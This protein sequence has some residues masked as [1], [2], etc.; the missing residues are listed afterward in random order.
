[1][2]AMDGAAVAATFA[3]AADGVML[4]LRKHVINDGGHLD[5]QLDRSTGAQVRS[6]W[7]FGA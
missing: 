6:H 5:E 1:M 4:R 7:V 2:A 3:A